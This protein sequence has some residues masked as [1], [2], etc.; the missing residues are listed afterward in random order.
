MAP[1][2]I[3]FAASMTTSVS[4]TT[5]AH[6]KYII[7]HLQKKKTKLVMKNVCLCNN[8]FC[9]VSRREI[10]TCEYN[11]IPIIISFYIKYI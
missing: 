5:I 6:V 4:T 8:L 11:N 3:R 7:H 10:K 2:S 9:V 1:K